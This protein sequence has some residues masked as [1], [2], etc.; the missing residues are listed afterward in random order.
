MQI[1]TTIKEDEALKSDRAKINELET[2]LLVNQRKAKY[3]AELISLNAQLEKQRNTK[4]IVVLISLL[5][6]LA[7][8]LI[9]YILSKNQRLKQSNLLMSEKLKAQESVLKER[10]RISRELHDEIGSTLSGI[11]MYSHI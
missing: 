11:S 6:I 10:S 9:Y 2:E 8:G 4:R 1:Y 3:E 7:A 5:I